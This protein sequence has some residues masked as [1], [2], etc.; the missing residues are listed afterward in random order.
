MA[1]VEVLG[2]VAELADGTVRSVDAATRAEVDPNRTFR[3]MLL[4]LSTAAC[5]FGFELD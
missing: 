5:L 3:F 2:G 1:I 4:T